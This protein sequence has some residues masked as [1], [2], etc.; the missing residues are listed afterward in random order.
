MRYILI[1]G[2][3]KKFSTIALGTTYFGT[4]IDEKTSFKLLD[5]FAH[6]GGTSV[7]TA[8]VYGQMDS[9]SLGK[10]EKIIGKWLKSNNMYKEMA[11][12]T[13]GGHPDIPSGTSRI[14]YTHIVKDL[15]M[16]FEALNT[17][18]ID[19]WFFHR[20]DTTKPVHY[21]V[22]ILNR[23]ESQ[24]PVTSFGA[25][26]WS[27]KRIEESHLYSYQNQ[28]PVIKASEIHYS[29]ATTDGVKMDD[30][31]LIFMDDESLNWYEEHQLPVFAFSSQ[32]KGFFT[33]ASQLK[34]LEMLN[35]KIT[36]RY[37]SAKNIATLEKVQQMSQ[38]LGISVTSLVIA[39]ITSSPFPSVSI[40][41]PSSVDQ[42][43][44]SLQDSDLTL[45]SL[46][47]RRLQG[48]E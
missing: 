14:S 24:F 1:E 13:K 12:I 3:K 48:K 17:D 18:T 29:L 32:A 36:S 21:M 41:G 10:S 34:S 42:L 11:I 22:D 37:V 46:M 28:A 7:D 40:I 43:K 15:Q 31:S 16:S 38:E 2:N 26:N 5:E 20:D 33:K 23:I 4:K 39:Y 25:S 19:M 27:T 45:P 9:N 8:L 6:R 35:E 47:R 30:D 44:D